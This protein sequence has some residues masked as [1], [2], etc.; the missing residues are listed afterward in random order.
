MQPRLVFDHVIMI[1]MRRTILYLYCSGYHGIHCHQRRDSAIA[2]ENQRQG[3][4]ISAFK[5]VGC[6]KHIPGSQIL[7]KKER[8][9]YGCYGVKEC[10]TYLSYA[11][12]QSWPRSFRLFS[13]MRLLCFC[14]AW[15]FHFSMVCLN[16]GR[17]FKI[18]GTKRRGDCIVRYSYL[19]LFRL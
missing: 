17:S 5:P 10:L 7:R 3:F 16:I 6:L 11:V 8:L 18:L 4:H 2:M 14:V 13:G 15:C 19:A 12:A 9:I 1:I